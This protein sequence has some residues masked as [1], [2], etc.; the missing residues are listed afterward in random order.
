VDIIVVGLLSL[1]LGAAVGALWA[2]SR[3][4]AKYE[5][6]LTDKASLAASLEAERRNAAEKVALLK[7]AE[8]KLRDAI[9]APLT[10]VP[11][12]SFTRSQP[13]NLLSI[14]RSNSALSRIRPSRSRKKR[15]AQIWRCLSGFLTPTIRPAFHAGLPRA[16]GSYCAIPISKLLWPKLAVR[17]IAEHGEPRGPLTAR[18][19]LA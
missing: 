5:S 18:Q 8:H 13:R 10:S 1:A 2:S 3:G 11:I 4:R 19:L 16:A 17:R 6:A 12:F 9:A 7:D 14:A 15:I